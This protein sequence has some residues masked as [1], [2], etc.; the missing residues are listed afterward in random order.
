MV[1]FLPCCFGL[2]D[3]TKQAEIIKKAEEQ[4]KMIEDANIDDQDEVIKF[5]KK[6]KAED[7]K[8]SIH[9]QLDGT[10]FPLTKRQI[11]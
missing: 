10:K 9:Y 2:K 6:N 1:T 4:M 8:I 3:G 7:S 11:R 5:L